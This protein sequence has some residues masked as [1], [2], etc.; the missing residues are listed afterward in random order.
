MDD[1][2]TIRQNI[3]EVVPKALIGS[4]SIESESR[5]QLLGGGPLFKT[6]QNNVDSRTVLAKGASRVQQLLKD[7]IVGSKFQVDCNVEM[8]TPKFQRILQRF[9]GQV[10]R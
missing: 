8:I 3:S 7:L 2:Q 6:Q 1:F 9:S 10:R 4:F 5:C